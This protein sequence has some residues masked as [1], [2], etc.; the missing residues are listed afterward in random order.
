MAL[1]VMT[2][3][4]AFGCGNSDTGDGAG[5]GGE[6]GTG[7]AG[8]TGGNPTTC[9]EEGGYA[10]TGDCNTCVHDSN[11]CGQYYDDCFGSGKPCESYQQGGCVGQPTTQEC[12]ACK[13]N[14]DHCRGTLCLVICSPDSA[15]Q[16]H[17]TSCPDLQKCCA[18]IT[19]ASDQIGCHD[20][21]RGGVES[22]FGGICQ[23]DLDDR[24]KK[25]ECP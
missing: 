23:D 7:A 19:N 13:S 4:L 18:A 24:H 11:Q 17:A 3:T 5:S 21:L 14:L 9:V 8:A 22:G 25:G 15:S 6:A 16:P 20:A 1:G 10:P 12:T 2:V